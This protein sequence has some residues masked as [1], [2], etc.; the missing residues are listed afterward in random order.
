MNFNKLVLIM[1]LSVSSIFAQDIGT[2]EVKVKEGFNPI[3]P[4][5]SRLNENATFADTIKKDRAQTYETID[6]GLKSDYKTK[7]LA[8]AQVRDDKIS[9]LYGTKIRVGFGSAWI[10]KAGIVHNSG[11][12][13]N[14][15]YGV[16][17]NHSANKYSLAQN[18]KN[19]INLYA[20]KIRP[21]CILMTNLDYDRRTALY[22]D[23]KLN[24]ME[25]KFFSNRFAY[26]KLSFTAIS[27]ESNPQGLKHYTTFFISDLNEFSENQIHLS[28]NLSKTIAGR[29][30][31]LGA[32]FNN[33]LRYN[34][35][36]SE[37]ENTD[38]KLLSFSPSTVFTKYGIDFSLGVDFNFLSDDS[39]IGFY[40]QIKLQKE[41][42]ED[43]LLF[44]G[45]LRYRQLGNTLK[46]LS[47]ENPYIHSFGTNQYI[48]AGDSF[49]QELKITD[50]QE[51]YLV[52][53]NVLG[54][55]EVLECGIAYGK[56][57]NFAHF[58]GTPHPI[59]NRF[60]VAYVDVK[61][62]HAN[63][64]YSRE[65]NSII[66]LNAN[67]NYFS[68]DMDIYNKPNFISN[69]SIPINLRDKIKVALSISYM[70][71][72]SIMDNISSELPAKIHSN[73]GLY[74]S[75]SKQLSAYLQLNNITNSKKDLWV[76][77]REM[78]FNAVFSINFSF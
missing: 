43:V 35:S 18:S 63:L 10:S 46:S 61:Q 8:V 6:A 4:E 26:T 20:K 12:S 74:Y 66:G 30:F 69:L 23:E 16:I 51:L 2:T 70:S 50:K 32:Q 21:S 47:D 27:K 5:A 28:S 29:P 72:R 73:L 56:I 22:Y 17:A 59:Y 1:L 11:R 15:S 14:L 64:N 31:N 55:E 62:F 34:N 25:D 77:Y 78:G 71:K 19:T 49:L 33:Y 75:Y 52:M 40:P 57:Q 42:V 41:L 13:K 9:Q 68:W 60:Q 7:P 24:L 54:V 36:Q 37:V 65:I 45:G 39:P 58:I 67:A 3:I 53:R 76:G 48:L 44:Y 38:L